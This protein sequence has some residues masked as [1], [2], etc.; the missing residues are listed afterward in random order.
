M[1]RGLSTGVLKTGSR[2]NHVIYVASCFMEGST[3]LRELFSLPLDD[4]VSCD[5]SFQSFI[6]IN[7]FIINGYIERWVIA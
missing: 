2:I 3:C 5:Y 1:M 6:I 7:H 4:V